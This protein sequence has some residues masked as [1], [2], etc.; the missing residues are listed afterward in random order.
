MNVTEKQGNPSHIHAILRTL[1]DIETP[2]G[3]AVVLSKIRGCVADLIHTSEAIEMQNLGFVSS[4]KQLIEILQTAKSYLTHRCH[5]RC[6]IRQTNA[7]GET[8]FVCKVQDNYLKGFTP[9]R[10]T[11]QTIPV[12]HTPD[13]KAIYNRLG[14][15][16][17]DVAL[18]E[19]L[20]SERHIPICSK[21]DPKFSP[22]NG[23]LFA[24]Y[25][26]S[27]NLQFTTGHAIAAYLVCIV[28]GLFCMELLI[29]VTHFSFLI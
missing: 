11:M 5:E 29:V 2:E 14:F 15:M 19:C 12:Y 22:T 25:Q 6:Q 23:H 17:G 9:S 1:F 20:K 21:D 13:A 7:S 10:H 24:C 18:H 8:V 28:F 4:A 16:D 3:L 27:Q 26:S